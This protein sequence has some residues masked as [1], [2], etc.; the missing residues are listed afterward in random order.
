MASTGRLGAVW[1][2]TWENRGT[3]EGLQS[4]ARIN[5]RAMAA[6]EIVL[7]VVDEELPEPDGG[8]WIVGA[9]YTVP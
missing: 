9:P 6:L 8:G 4:C 7:T 1:C 2:R 5:A 3:R